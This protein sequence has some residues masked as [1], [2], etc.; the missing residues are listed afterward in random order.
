MKTKPFGYEQAI[1]ENKKFSRFIVSLFGESHFGIRARQIWLSRMFQKHLSSTTK[2][3]LD[4]GCGKGHTS[5]WLAKYCPAAS[6]E[7]IDINLKEL[8]HCLSIQTALKLHNVTFQKSDIIGFSSFKKYDF[9]L[10]VDVLEHIENWQQSIQSLMELLNSKGVLLIHLPHSGKYQE[11][12]YGFR[13]FQ[14]NKPLPQSP[15]E[16]MGHVREGLAAED[17][18]F[19]KNVPGFEVIIR[20]TFGDFTML[21]HTL[22]ELYRS[23]SRFFRFLFNP[24]LLFV[25]WMES[26]QCH[27]SLKDGGGILI[28]IRRN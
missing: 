20:Y 13:K 25:T 22:F 15:F 1:L 21:S 4:A 14:R 17:F 9:I 16:G 6:V 8:E 23:R 18:D 3:I 26:R 12:H 7:G 19:L 28:E 27:D 11:D 10:C 2:N 5:F 24:I